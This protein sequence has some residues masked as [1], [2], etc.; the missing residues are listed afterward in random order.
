M[1]TRKTGKIQTLLIGG[2]YNGYRI[3]M[4]PG[5]ESLSFKCR[6]F[7]GHYKTNGR[8][9]S[10]IVEVKFEDNPNFILGYN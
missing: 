4:S 1:A 9:Q 6:E 5:C 2:P 10:E 3:P 7:F 8:W